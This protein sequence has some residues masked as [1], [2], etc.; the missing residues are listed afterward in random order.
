M[1]LKCNYE[2]ADQVCTIMVLYMTRASSHTS[3][4]GSESREPNLR[5]Y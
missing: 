3:L 4:R 5:N 1:E 2:F